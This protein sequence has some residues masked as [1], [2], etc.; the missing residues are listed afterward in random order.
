V[1]DR[2]VNAM[3]NFDYD[4]FR[5][6]LRSENGQV[7]AIMSIGGKGAPSTGGQGLNLNVRVT[8]VVEHL[9]ELLIIG[10]KI[11]VGQQ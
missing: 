11:G 6:D 5:I 3:K 8:G 9:S 4:T 10:R 2:I 7:V 1:R